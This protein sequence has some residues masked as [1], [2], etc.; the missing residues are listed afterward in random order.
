MRKRVGCPSGKGTLVSWRDRDANVGVNIDGGGWWEGFAAEI[1]LLPPSEQE[2]P[3]PSKF[4]DPPVKD[5]DTAD[6]P[7]NDEPAHVRRERRKMEASP[8]S[9]GERAD[10]RRREKEAADDTESRRFAES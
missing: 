9:D 6:L 8:E 7:S 1:Y 5:V 3:R 10:R 4:I 2:D